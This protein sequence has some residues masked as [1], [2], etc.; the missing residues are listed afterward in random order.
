MAI[1]IG[2]G[3][4]DQV[5]RVFVR[6]SRVGILNNNGIDLDKIENRLEIRFN[7]SLI[8]LTIPIIPG[9]GHAFVLFPS[10]YALFQALLFFSA[11]LFQQ[12]IVYMSMKGKRDC[13]CRS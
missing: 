1:E 13:H 6:V 9:R 10:M 11:L 2:P 12:K 3:I 7:Q 8:A 4:V 5:L